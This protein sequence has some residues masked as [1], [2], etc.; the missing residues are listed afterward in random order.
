LLAPSISVSPTRKSLFSEIVS[1]TVEEVAEPIHD[2][3]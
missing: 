2:G 1:S 3:C